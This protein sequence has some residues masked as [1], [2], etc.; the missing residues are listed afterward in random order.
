MHCIILM[1]FTLVVH[2]DISLRNVWRN[3][4]PYLVHFYDQVKVLYSVECEVCKRYVL[5]YLRVSH[6]FTQNGCAESH[7]LIDA[8]VLLHIFTHPFSELS[9]LGMLDMHIDV[10]ISDS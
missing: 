2:Q 6:S 1:H 9:V 4:L 3:K 7:G 5:F 10:A 8:V